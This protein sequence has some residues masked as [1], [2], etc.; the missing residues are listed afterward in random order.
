MILI[1]SSSFSKTN[2]SAVNIIILSNRMFLVE[3]TL[4]FENTQT[5]YI[6]IDSY[7]TSQPIYAFGS[8]LSSRFLLRLYIY[9]LHPNLN[10]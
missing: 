10:I 8:S 6:F 1:I 7:P 2:S 9:V 5:L 4:Y 3:I